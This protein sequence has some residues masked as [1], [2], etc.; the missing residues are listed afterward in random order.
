MKKITT[1]LCAARQGQARINAGIKVICLLLLGISQLTMAQT[2]ASKVRI[3]M[4]GA[5][6]DD[7]DMK[8]GGTA[9]I[10]SSMGH[11]VK[12]VSVTNGDAGHQNDKGASLAK[13]RFAEA[14]EAGKRFGVTY[15][16]L[17]NHDGE[18]L[19]TLEVRLQIIKKIREWNADVVIAPRPN[20]YHPDHR[21]TGILVQDAAYMV[22]VPN[23]APETPPLKKN[24]I[25]LYFQDSFER[26]NPFRPDVAV[27]ISK[28]FTQK[29]HAMD[30]HESQMYEW[31]PWIGNHA[32]DVPKNK[33]DREKWLAQ[34]RTVKITPE[35]RKSLEKWYGAEKAA[36]VQHAESFEICEYGARPT[37]ADIKRLFPMLGSN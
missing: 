1:I 6:P 18:L 29:I 12:F 5:H 16:V 14:Q 24:P 17:N 4:I 15:D 9:A 25:F 3:I 7:C 20:D 30:A 13:R 22:A 23:V 2:D 19:P 28:V 35:V 37:E 10:L 36:Q 33:A 26:P 27:D 31:L 32:S 11:A 21:Y 8:G 34:T